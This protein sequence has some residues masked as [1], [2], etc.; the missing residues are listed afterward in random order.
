MILRLKKRQIPSGGV[1]LKKTIFAVAVLFLVS[2]LAA[3]AH[4][5][6]ESFPDNLNIQAR[7]DMNGFSVK[8]AAQFGVPLRQAQAIIK[9]VEAPPT[10]SCAFSSA[11]W[12]INNP[13]R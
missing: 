2:R 10:P 4:A 1:R 7:A 11:R 13:R 3:V 8:L 6:L 12:Q 5:Q 9:T